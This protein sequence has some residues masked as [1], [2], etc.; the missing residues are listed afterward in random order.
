M[1]ILENPKSLITFLVTLT[2]ALALIRNATAQSSSEMQTFFS[3]DYAGISI[4]V[5]ATKE[6]IPGGNTGIGLWINCTSAGVKVDYLNLSVYGF[7]SGKEKILLNFTCALPNAPISLNQT[8]EYNYNVSIP[9]DVWDATY[10]EL[11][12]K[13]AIVDQPIERNAGFQMTIV[14]NVYLEELEQQLKSLNE[15]YQQLNNTLE[16]LNQTFWESFQINLSTENLAYLNKTYWEL[17]HNYTALQGSLNELGN[18]RSAV[19]ALAITTAIF[20]A[21][22]I[23]MIMR[24]PKQ[25]W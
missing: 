5:N 11:Y 24:K 9:S 1:R 23:Y 14:R 2:L 15:S 19:A 7:K 8:I 25:Y 16:Q 13:Y 4:T 18:T 22:T 10:G 21:T 17:Q 6:T 20:V 3:K 12:L